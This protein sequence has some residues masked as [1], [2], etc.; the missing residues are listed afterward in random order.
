ML[1]QPAV[2][3]PTSSLEREPAGKAARVPVNA[4]RASASC[5]TLLVHEIRRALSRAACTAGSSR[6]MS[7]AMMAMTTSSST[8]VKPRRDR[9]RSCRR[10]QSPRHPLPGHRSLRII[11][12]PPLASSAQPHRTPP[13][14]G[15]QRLR[16]EIIVGLR[17][18]SWRSHLI[19][20]QAAARCG[21]SRSRCP[22]RVIRQPLGVTRFRR[23]TS[24]LPCPDCS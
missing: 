20:P 1:H 23:N 10:G 19:Q 12:R 13:R 22:L 24:S 9:R 3:L 16:P 2:R 5:L 4:W 15:E 21:V 18:V 6:P 11:P 7:T 8:S 14:R 17:P